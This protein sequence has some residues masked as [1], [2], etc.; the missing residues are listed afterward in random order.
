MI[1]YDLE[2]IQYKIELRIFEHN[3]RNFDLDLF[4]KQFDNDSSSYIK[5]ASFY[6]IIANNLISIISTWEQQLFRFCNNYIEETENNF[7]LIRNKYLN[8]GIDEK[9]FDSIKEYRYVNNVLKHG[10]ASTSFT[11]LQK[12]RSKFI[13]P[14]KKYKNLND[15]NFNMPILNIDENSIYELCKQIETFWTKIN[16]HMMK[17][18]KHL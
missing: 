5:E 14:N 1:F 12:L 8:F 6:R 3:L 9:L 2:I 11:K 13:N 18:N 15:D 10:K 16:D 17:K 4:V 7:N